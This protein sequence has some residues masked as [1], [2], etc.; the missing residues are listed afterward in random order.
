MKKINKL[1]LVSTISLFF[2][3]SVA[4]TQAQTLTADVVIIGAGTA[5]LPAAVEAAQK[6]AKVIIF[7]KTNKTGGQANMGSGAFAVES[8]LQKRKNVSLTREQAFKIFMEHTHWQVDARLV[9]EY[10]NQSGDTISW[11]ESLGVEFADAA[12][13]TVGSYPTH[14][15]VD[16]KDIN[17][18]PNTRVGIAAMMNAIAERVRELGVEIIFETPVKKIIKEKGRITGVVAEDKSGNQ[19]RA[20]AKAVIV[21]TGGFANNPDMIKEFTRYEWGK[22]IFSLRLPGLDGD[23]IKMAWEVGA[24]KEGMNMELTS[25]V[26]G[27]SLP[28]ASQAG[29]A[30]KQPN[31]M[32]NVQGERFMNEEAMGNPT[33]AGNAVARQKDGCG[34]IIF[35]AGI[36]EDYEKNGFDWARSAPTGETGFVA[37][38]TK[39]CKDAEH[40]FVADTLE[41]LAAKTGINYPALQKTVEVYNV[42]AET[43][44]D[45]IFFKDAQYL[46]PIKNGPFFAGRHYPSAYASL[47]GIKINYKTEVVTDDHEVIPGL[48][49]AGV[50]AATIYFDSYMFIFPGNTMG[51]ALNSGRIAGRNSADYALKK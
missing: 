46:R 18:T 42:A 37:T 9:S 26:P 11:I 23:G 8:P 38:L 28:L 48:Y 39:A 34:F 15:R 4:V 25:G 22:T 21:C 17:R 5:G 3:F 44:R 20:N 12:S 31:L 19:V 1:W 10:I 29:S 14:H 40:M 7:E 6:G 45:K 50:D 51:F 41:E 2:I 27:G 49:A 32:V 13:H 16:P 30:F 36:V 33:Y 43:G 47:G 35:D 24:G